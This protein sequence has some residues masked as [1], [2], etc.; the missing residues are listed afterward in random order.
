MPA[1]EDLMARSLLV[2][3]LLPLLS[4]FP[5]KDLFSLINC[6]SFLPLIHITFFFISH[7]SLLLFFFLVT[8]I[9]II[10]PELTLRHFN[11][12]IEFS[13]WK[14]PFPLPSFLDSQNMALLC[15]LACLDGVT[16]TKCQTFNAHGKRK[17]RT[18]LI[19][20]RMSLSLNA[21]LIVQEFKGFLFLPLS[22]RDKSL[23]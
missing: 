21:S 14:C 16:L 18:F 11:Q 17:R 10:C 15:L 1:V 3:S 5:R 6:C 9:I 4:T 2:L 13:A 8:R 23:H 20:G 7:S 12:Y 19:S 22:F